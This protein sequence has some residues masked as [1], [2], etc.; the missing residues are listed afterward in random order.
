MLLDLIENEVA[1]QSVGDLLVGGFFTRCFGDKAFDRLN[2]FQYRRADGC[3]F[4]HLM[5]SFKIVTAGTCPLFLELSFSPLSVKHG[6]S[7]LNLFDFCGPFRQ[8]KF[9]GYRSR[10]AFLSCAIFN[11]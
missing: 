9:E 5:A 3:F 4:F 6:L 10:R 11:L 1:L 2:G 8:G 7:A